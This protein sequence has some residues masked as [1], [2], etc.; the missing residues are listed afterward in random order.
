MLSTVCD[1]YGPPIIE[2]IDDP[3]ELL[4]QI[5]EC[6]QFKDE[7]GLKTYILEHKLKAQSIFWELILKIG[8]HMNADNNENNQAFFDVC[9]RCLS[10]LIKVGNPKETLLAVLEQMDSSI[11]DV[12]FKCFL[13]LIQTSLLKFQKKMFHSL[14]I[15]LETVSAHIKDIPVPENDQLEGDEI[16]LFHLDKTVVRL[17]ENS[18][19]FFNFLEPFVKAIDVTQLEN[20]HIHEAVVLK[21]Y[22]VQLFDHP[23]CHLIISH[24]KLEN[25]QKSDGRVC[26]EQAMDLLCHLETNFYYLF[27]KNEKESHNEKNNT[28]RD[29]LPENDSLPFSE[30]ND[31]EENDKR[32]KKI[33]NDVNKIEVGNRW[34]FNINISPHSQACIAY[35]LHCENLGLHKFPAIFTHKHILELHLENI[36]LLLEST[37]YPINMK[38]LQLAQSLIHLV[39]K[40]CI[41]S[42]E[43]DN[44]GY[45]KILNH[46]IVIM[47]KCPVKEHRLL[48]TKI[49]PLLINKFV[50]GGRHK[51]YVNVLSSCFHSGVKGFLITCIKDD[52]ANN[53]NHM[54]QVMSMTEDEKKLNMDKSKETVFIGK[55]L[56]K[57][58]KLALHLPENE[59]T[60]ML[61]NSDQIISGL[62][63]LR[64]LVM[65]DPAKENLTNFWNYVSDIETS[66]IAPLRKGLDLSKAHYKLEL[67]NVSAGRMSDVGRE[68]VPEMSVQVGGSVLP[69]VEKEEKLNLI[70]KALLTHDIMIG[71][72]ARLSELICQNNV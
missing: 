13:S 64:F 17:I 49:F 52:I 24:D 56:E 66:F 38:G 20:Q 12:K 43:L 29:L 58:L 59:T 39:D 1:N 63:F 27:Q 71:L 3:Q 62:N 34:D 44:P 2:R 25:R 26:A 23:L 10:Y 45:L 51:I 55:S 72:V 7:K 15:A 28:L 6:L 32:V 40:D 9:N 69:A 65:A 41:A 60:D 8:E 36:S 47:T 19:A 42:D 5:T 61:E 50:S 53:L 48:S 11:D 68:N 70:Q 30:A 35:L 54:K 46:L 18:Q 33:V 37:I 22:L 57:L 14:D 31:N 21:K 16:K 4:A 67:D